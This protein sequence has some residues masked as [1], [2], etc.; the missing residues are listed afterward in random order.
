MAKARALKNKYRT[1]WGGD[2][3]ESTRCSN[4]TGRVTRAAVHYDML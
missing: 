3:G 4:N 1:D 2:R